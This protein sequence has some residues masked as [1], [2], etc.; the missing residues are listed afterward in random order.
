MLVHLPSNQLSMTLHSLALMHLVSSRPHHTAHDPQIP[1]ANT[2]TPLTCHRHPWSITPILVL[3]H[4]KHSL[5][6]NRQPCHVLCV[7]HAHQP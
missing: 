4:M 1:A 6:P 5:L 3:E 2:I 7:Q